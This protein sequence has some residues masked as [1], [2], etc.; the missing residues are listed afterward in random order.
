MKVLRDH[1]DAVHLMPLAPSEKYLGWG[2]GF[3]RE[4]QMKSA[5]GDIPTKHT[6]SGHM[7]IFRRAGGSLG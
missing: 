2:G 4:T 5:S 7:E 3:G 6:Y 1:R